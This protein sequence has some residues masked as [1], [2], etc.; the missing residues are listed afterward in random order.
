MSDKP[1]PVR[2][3]SLKS[4]TSNTVTLKWEEPEK[5][6]GSDITGYVVERKEAQ[7]KMWQSVTTTENLEFE[8]T[9]LFEGNQYHFRVAAENSIGVGDYTELQQ[10]VQP[11][12]QFSK[13]IYT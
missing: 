12:C 2:N 11:K 13:Q 9:G 3:L 1:G 8:V 5:D 10:T 6:G 7:R 4:V